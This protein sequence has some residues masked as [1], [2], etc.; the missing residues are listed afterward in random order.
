MNKTL[1][2]YHTLNLNFDAGYNVDRVYKFIN[3]EVLVHNHVDL[4]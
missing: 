3:L 2:K 4:L 1:K